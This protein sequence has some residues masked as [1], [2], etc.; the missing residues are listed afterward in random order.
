MDTW[1]PTAPQSWISSLIVDQRSIRIGGLQPGHGKRCKITEGVHTAPA[2]AV[3]ED[4]A[5]TLVIVDDQLRTLSVQPELFRRHEGWPL[6]APID[7]R[8]ED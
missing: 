6:G 1:E 4:Q 5:D 3:L 7:S 2:V 8:A